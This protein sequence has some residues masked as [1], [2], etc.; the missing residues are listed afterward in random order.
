MTPEIT[1]ADIYEDFDLDI[2]VQ[3]VSS[4]LHSVGL[5]LSSLSNF[6]GCQRDSV[7]SSLGLSMGPYF[8]GKIAIRLWRIQ[9]P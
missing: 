2:I 6:P 1:P 5:I 4:S 3:S 9:E 8:T 7:E